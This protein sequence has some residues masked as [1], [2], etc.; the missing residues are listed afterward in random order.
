M[1]SR[2]FGIGES[3]RPEPSNRGVK[4]GFPTAA[5]W[6]R[7][8][9][10]FAQCI[11]RH[12]CCAVQKA[13]GNAI[14]GCLGNRL[15]N[16]HGDAAIAPC[17]RHCANKSLLCHAIGYFA[18]QRAIA[19]QPAIA[20]YSKR[21]CALQAAHAPRSRPL[22]DTETTVKLH[23]SLKDAVRVIIR[24]TIPPPVDRDASA[25]DWDPTRI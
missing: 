19:M 24:P 23:H 2:E 13:I 25:P 14:G 17:N 6:A 9:L 20:P 12:H 21:S 11:R 15:C 22:R 4:S 5:D 8:C 18:M 7:R 10:A 16:R 3:R 1:R